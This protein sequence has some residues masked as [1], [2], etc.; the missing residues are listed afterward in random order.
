MN[1]ADMFGKLNEFQTKMKE[2]QAQLGEIETTAEAGG[3][4]VKV[5]AN[6]QRKVVRIQIEPDIVDPSDKEMLED[7]IVAG[8]NKA[9]DEAEKLAQDKMAEMTKGFIPPGGIP[10]FDMSKFGQ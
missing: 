3:G 7:L 1:M 9:L 2:T 5:T 6:G 4:M 10:G 8:V